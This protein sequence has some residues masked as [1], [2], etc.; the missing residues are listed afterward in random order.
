MF[1]HHFL[2][3]VL[4]GQCHENFD[5]RF[6]LEI[7]FPQAPLSIPLGPFQIF[8]EN[9]GDIRSSRCNTH[10][11]DTGG[12]WKKYSFRKDLNILFGHFGVVEL[13]WRLFFF[14]FKFTLRCKKSD[15]VPIFWCPY[16]AGKFTAGVVDTGGALWHANISAN[17][18]K[19][20]KWP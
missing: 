14:F 18:R 7:S 20:S 12:K 6:F 2:L 15:I 19:K 9:F 4:K 5:F 13:T 8:F 3:I 1:K 16:T 11:V 17:V 10:V